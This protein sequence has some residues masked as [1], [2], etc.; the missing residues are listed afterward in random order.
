MA[1]QIPPSSK[2]RERSEHTEFI[3]KLI[4]LIILSKHIYTT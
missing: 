2:F 3:L 4:S 1:G